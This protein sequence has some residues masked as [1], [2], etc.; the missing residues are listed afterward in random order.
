VTSTDLDIATSSRLA[1]LPHAVPDPMRAERTRSRCR[2]HLVRRQRRRNHA[3]STIRLARSV[4]TAVAVGG[5]VTLCVLY[6]SSLVAT[7]LGIEGALRP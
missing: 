6:V 5:F 4:L 3:A 2:A 1:S 7:T